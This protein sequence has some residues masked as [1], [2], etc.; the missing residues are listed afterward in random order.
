MSGHAQVKEQ[1]KVTQAGQC[2]G[3]GTT[4]VFEVIA[5]RKGAARPLVELN[6]SII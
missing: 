4:T 2:A 3:G 6:E 1:K 5:T